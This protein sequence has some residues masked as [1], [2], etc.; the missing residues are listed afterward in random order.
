MLRFPALGENLPDIWNVKLANEFHM[1]NDSNLF[2]TAAG[3]GRLPLYEGKMIHQFTHQWGKPRYWV[4]EAAGRRSLLGRR[5]DIGQQLDYQTY[6]LGFRDVAR[7]TDE[8]TMISTVL[9]PVVFAGNTLALSATLSE[10]D[11][12]TVTSILNSFAADYLIRKKVTAHCSFFYVYQLPIPR[13][14]ASDPAF[15]PI[16]E[17][18]AKLI[19]T[20][21]EFD[22]LAR[23]VGLGDHSHGV[24][25]PVAR[26]QLR[27]EL[28]GM[29]AHVYGLTEAEFAHILSAFPLVPEPTKVAAQNA[30]RDIQ[31][32]VMQWQ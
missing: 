19:C 27:A 26:A 28:D 7:N 9:P 15:A 6:R 14:T 18:A 1:T 2:H 20:T 4:D 3:P 8:R 29:I 25:D 32:G 22:D 12:L 10:K 13:L 16:V 24:S 23:A 30:Y 21:P 11:L 31:R 17:R 5:D